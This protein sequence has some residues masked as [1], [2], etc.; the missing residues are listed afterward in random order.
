MEIGERFYA[1]TRGEWREWLDRHWGKLSEIWLVRYKKHTKVECV[2]YDDAVEEA[3]CFGW[4]DGLVKRVD[5][6]TFVIRFTPR[7]PRSV[8]SQSNKRRIEKMLDAGRMQAPG[9]ALVEQAK[10][11]GA[12]DKADV[13]ED[14]S[15][16]PDE[17]A[18]A[19]STNESAKAFYDGLTPGQRRHYKAWVHTAK[20]AET[21]Q[22]RAE[23]VAQRCE[24]GLKPGMV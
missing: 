20:R 18:K 1:R 12:W 5:D 24:E 13:I 6:E 10:R 17:L 23:V 21:R 2:P 22:R 3:L 9:L 15:S 4:I 7:K 16:I 14:H 19:L 8:W 11:S